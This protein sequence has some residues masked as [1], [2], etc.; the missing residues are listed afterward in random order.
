VNGNDQESVM[1]PPPGNSWSSWNSL[2]LRDLEQQVRDSHR[3]AMILSHGNADELQR[4]EAENAQLRLY[5]TFILNLLVA[6]KLTS[7]QEINQWMQAFL[8]TAAQPAQSEAPPL[9]EDS[10]FGNLGRWT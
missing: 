10:P 4:L 9:P 5:V 6:K 3:R 7:E 1:N 2:R 8:Q